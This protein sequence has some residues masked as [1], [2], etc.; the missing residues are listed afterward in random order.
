MEEI[1]VDLI[2][3]KE[4]ASRTLLCAALLS[5]VLPIYNEEQRKMFRL[6]FKQDLTEL[7][8]AFFQDLGRFMIKNREESLPYIRFIKE[9]ADYLLGISDDEPQVDI[10]TAAMHK[11]IAKQ[12]KSLN[13][14]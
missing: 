5:D 6:A 9:V 4:F 13:L 2:D 7:I 11:K 10:D 3:N 8:P 12:L 14:S 1:R